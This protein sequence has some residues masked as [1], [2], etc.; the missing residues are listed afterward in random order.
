MKKLSVVLIIIGLLVIAY[1]LI[2]KFY[3]SY[4]QN[5]LISD[6]ENG[7]LP[8]VTQK[9]NTS[10]NDFFTLQ[11]IFNNER[12]L[13]LF[14]SDS[15]QHNPTTVTAPLTGGISK[16]TVSASLTVSPV[17]TSTPKPAATPKPQIVLG[18]MKIS[19]IKVNDPIVEGVAKE[20]LRVGLGHLPGT[21]GIGEI[22]N[23]AIAG[24]RSYT[25]GRFFNRLDEIKMGDIIII[26]TK[27][28][29]FTYEVYEILV[30]EPTDTSVLKKNEGE[31][32]LTLIT[33]T[34]K[35]VATHRLIVH[36]KLVETAT[37]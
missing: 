3:T 8:E 7:L 4:L 33:C 24:H 13:N 15:D 14:D 21:A 31:K 19:K 10:E 12:T 27:E 25:F 29:V 28:F 9:S 17:A 23:C 1:P 11:N 2:G 35:M 36:A 18:I 26:E 30:V 16:E 34:P 32:T 22:G 20:N 6:W 37:K 5:K